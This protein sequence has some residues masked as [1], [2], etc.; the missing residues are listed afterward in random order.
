MIILP[1]VAAQTL[2]LVEA[3]RTFP[4]EVRMWIRIRDRGRFNT[5]EIF[6]MLLKVSL[7]AHSAVMRARTY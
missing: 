3:A 4:A 7:P 2:I 6:F 1:D 5:S